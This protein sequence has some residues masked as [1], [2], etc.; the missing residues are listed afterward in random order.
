ME[1][2]ES[3]P[4][5]P[6]ALVLGGACFGVFG[7]LMGWRLAGID[8]WDA[9]W[10]VVGVVLAGLAGG[11]FGAA[12]GAILGAAAGLGARGPRAGAGRELAAGGIVMLVPF[13]VLAA[14]AEILLGWSAS[15]AF[16]SAGLMTSGGAIG[17]EVVRRGGQ[18]RRAT[19]VPVVAAALLATAWTAIAAIAASV[20]P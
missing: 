1:A 18:G 3:R 20:K 11:V 6:G 15:V 19:L 12:A 13:V 9:T 16:A 2:S 14:A 5:G 10:A 4:S 7:L 8:A 17:V